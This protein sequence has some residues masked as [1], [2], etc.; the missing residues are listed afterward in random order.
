[1]QANWNDLT[2]KDPQT[3]PVFS[4]T[5]GV[6]RGRGRRAK[7]RKVPSHS[8]E[9]CLTRALVRRP[10]DGGEQ[11]TT[12]HQ[13][14]C[15]KGPWVLHLPSKTATP[16][17][18]PCLVLGGQ[19]PPGDQ[20]GTALGSALKKKSHIG[21]G[22]ELES[23]PNLRTGILLT[24]LYLLM[25]F[26]HP[27]LS[28]RINYY[29]EFCIYKFPWFSLYQFITN[30]WILKLYSFLGYFPD[31]PVVETLHLHCRGHEFDPRSGN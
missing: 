6:W 5:W 25:S 24:L 3:L 19:L 27:T 16:C 22:L 7:T 4:C 20:P 29:F 17:C 28:S 12:M 13:L 23:S 26:S 15:S 30:V 14:V 11:A 10:L 2:T 9:E 21:F 31:F 8:E 18:V 1:M